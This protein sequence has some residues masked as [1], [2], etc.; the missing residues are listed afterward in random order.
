MGAAKK[1]KGRTYSYKLP[2]MHWV[3]PP[4]TPTP[5]W[6][7]Q[8]NLSSHDQFSSLVPSSDSDSATS[9]TPA[10]SRAQSFTNHEVCN[11]AIQESR[12]R[13]FSNQL[14][15]QPIDR[16]AKPLHSLKGDA[17]ASNPFLKTA[18]VTAFSSG[19]VV[20]TR[21]ST[22]FGPE[23]AQRPWPL[24]LRMSSD[25]TS[26]DAMPSP[27]YMTESWRQVTP[28]SSHVTWNLKVVAQTLVA[29]VTGMLAHVTVTF[30]Q[31]T[32]GTGEMARGAL[33]GSDSRREE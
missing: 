29:H 1:L 30:G 24:V 33:H 26:S 6:P 13:V 19:Q 23:A 16:V 15:E 5:T 22:G 4:V 20:T 12:A 17:A 2:Q 9:W 11:R 14:R 25:T 28:P 18:S 31:A 8:G 10:L 7:Q 21:L 3:Q 32:C 27:G